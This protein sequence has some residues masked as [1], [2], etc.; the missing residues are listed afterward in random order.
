[1]I[2]DKY[3][4]TQEYVDFYMSKLP[5]PLKVWVSTGLTVGEVVTVVDVWRELV[6]IQGNGRPHILTFDMLKLMVKVE[7]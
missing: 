7:V 3:I 2:G 5:E 6:D 4:V 1:M